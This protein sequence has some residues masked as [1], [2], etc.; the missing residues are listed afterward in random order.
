M[1]LRQAQVSLSRRARQA[2]TI[3][4]IE[5][6]RAFF[7][8][9]GLWVYAL[10]LLPAVAFIGHAIDAKLQTERLTRR[11][12]TDPALMNTI[13]QGEALEA[14][15][16]RLGKPAEERW[17]IRTRR[18]RQRTAASGTTAH[19]IEPAVDARFVRLNIFRP[20]YSGDDVARM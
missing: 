6:R 14:V 3:A 18:V 15:K 20:N 10:A 19:V 13:Q 8:K 16:A 9:R 11:G 2:W 7:A 5:L 4:A 17:S 1:P 12:V